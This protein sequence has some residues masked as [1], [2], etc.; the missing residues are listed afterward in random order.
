MAVIEFAVVLVRNRL[1]Y[2]PEELFMAG[3]DPVIFYLV[4]P[5][6]VSLLL[7]TIWTRLIMFRRER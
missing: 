5:S 6:L 3:S 1:L 2:L 4:L 7:I